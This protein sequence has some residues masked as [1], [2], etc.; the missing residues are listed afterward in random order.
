MQVNA[1]TAQ[2]SLLPQSAECVADRLSPGL[3]I[4]TCELAFVDQHLQQIVTST[5]GFVAQERPEAIDAS[6]INMFVG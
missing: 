2:T 5:M 1:T 6:L 3:V 4:L